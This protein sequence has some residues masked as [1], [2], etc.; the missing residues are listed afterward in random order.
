MVTFFWI[1]LSLCVTLGLFAL[2]AMVWP[3]LA[4][5]LGDLAGVLMF[6]VSGIVGIAYMRKHRRPESP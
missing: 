1:V 4:S 2:A 3:N 5:V 6:L